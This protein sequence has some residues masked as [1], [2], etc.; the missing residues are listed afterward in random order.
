MISPVSREKARSL[1]RS[2]KCAGRGVVFCVKNE[3]NMRIHLTAAVYVLVFSAFYGF[4]AAEYAL[5]ILVISSVIAAEAVNTAIEAAVDMGAPH[6]DSLARIAKDA[7]AGAVLVTAVGAAAIGCILFI[8][9]AVL[10]RIAAFFA[11]S[12]VFIAI[13]VLSLAAAVVFIGKPHYNGRTKIKKI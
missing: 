1:A 4:S 9:P 6:Y 3:R 10:A 7:A 12:P 13:L 11:H 8:R 2:F 5:L